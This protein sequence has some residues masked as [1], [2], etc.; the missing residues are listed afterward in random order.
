ML[1]I[2]IHQKEDFVH[3]TSPDVQYWPALDSFTVLTAFE[4]SC[5]KG[6]LHRAQSIAGLYACKLDVS[7]NDCFA[8]RAACQN[9]HA[10]VARW[11]ASSFDDSVLD[12]HALNHYA[13]REACWGG[14]T[15]VAMWLHGLGGVDVNATRF[16]F[17]F[18]TPFVGA[19]AS[20]AL[21]LAQWL[22]AMCDAAGSGTEQ[23]HPAFQLACTYGHDAVAQWLLPN[24]N[25]VCLHD[26]AMRGACVNGHA[27]LSHWL[28]S[29]LPKRCFTMQSI[30]MD[31]CSHGDVLAIWNTWLLCAPYALTHQRG[32]Q[33][34]T[35]YKACRSG[36]LLAAMFV[37]ELFN[38]HFN[39]GVKNRA[40][41]R[42]CQNG[43][44]EIAQWMYELEAVDAVVCERAFVFVLKENVGQPL[45]AVLIWL[46]SLRAVRKDRIVAAT[47]RLL[48]DAGC[49]EAYL[50]LIR[51]T[52]KHVAC[53]VAV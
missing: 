18:E 34:K 5:E 30:F 27:S 13:F 42:A 23:T 16:C 35:I 9:G 45:H 52:F 11:L 1:S 19:C 47:K 12:R 15:A 4:R 26:A 14:H 38:K 31:V 48:V 41:L 32:F 20:G 44:L 49:K 24:V 10:D 17:E 43:H 25:Y 2:S 3:S 36:N 46:A 28:A 6:L 50:E 37:A 39:S 29:A 51:V 8:F 7:N 53:G 22:W 33:V 21:D 40:F